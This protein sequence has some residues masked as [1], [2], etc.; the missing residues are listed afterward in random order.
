MAVKALNRVH[1][2]MGLQEVV[3]SCLPDAKM[4]C[5]YDVRRGSWPLSG[6][7]EAKCH[8]NTG[9]R[10][11]M[12]FVIKLWVECSSFEEGES[13]MGLEGALGSDNESGMWCLLGAKNGTLSTSNLD[14]FW[15]FILAGISC[16][17]WPVRVKQVQWHLL[18]D[19]LAQSKPCSSIFG[20]GLG[21]EVWKSETCTSMPLFHQT[22]VFVVIL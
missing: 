7:L 8:V 4:P 11:F 6:I 17:W 18:G 21:K 3:G 20:K 15:M 9:H 1:R 10:I 5:Q 14:C 19:K 22:S 13:E 2:E 12:A 16:S